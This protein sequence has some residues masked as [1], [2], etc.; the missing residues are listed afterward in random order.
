MQPT[1][2]RVPYTFLTI[3]IQS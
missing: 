2:L 1:K 3:Y